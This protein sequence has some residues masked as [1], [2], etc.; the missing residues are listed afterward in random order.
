MFLPPREK[1]REEQEQKA[2]IEF[3]NIAGIIKLSSTASKAGSVY[4]D[5]QRVSSKIVQR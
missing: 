3:V 2:K 5:V 4:E 1:E